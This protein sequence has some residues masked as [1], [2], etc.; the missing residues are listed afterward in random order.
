MSDDYYWSVINGERRPYDKCPRCYKYKYR[1]K[2]SSQFVTPMDELSP[3]QALHRMLYVT[4]FTGHILA[5]LGLTQKR[6]MTI[7][8][9][10]CSNC[11]LKR[12]ED[13]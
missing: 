12:D 4:P 8:Y 5:I 3:L 9:Y 7:D 6:E 11:R 2:G 13:D 1:A 10:W